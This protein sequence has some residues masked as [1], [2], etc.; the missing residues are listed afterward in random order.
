MYN[1]MEQ[2][3]KELQNKLNAIS[4]NNDE[5]GESSTK[6]KIRG[7]KQTVHKLQQRYDE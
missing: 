5:N 1:I 3:F 2:K 7:V 4:N 6:A